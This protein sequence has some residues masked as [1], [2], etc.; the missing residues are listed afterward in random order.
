MLHVTSPSKGV[1]LV[2]ELPVPVGRTLAGG[3]AVYD[4]RFFGNV[5]DAGQR[6]RRPEKTADTSKRYW[7]IFSI[8]G[9]NM[10]GK[11]MNNDQ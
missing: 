3:V 4:R 1:Y 2:N 8:A 7:D 5:S 6:S 9:K 11:L 10:K